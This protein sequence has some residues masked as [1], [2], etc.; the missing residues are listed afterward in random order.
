MNRVL[1]YTIALD[2]KGSR[3]HALMAKLLATSLQRTF[4]SGDVVIFRNSPQ[5]LFFSERKRVEEVYLPAGHVGWAAS[6]SWKWRVLEQIEVERYDWVFFVDCDCL[7]L[8]NIDHLLTG[9]WDFIYQTEQPSMTGHQ[10]NCFLTDEEMRS[11]A[12]R[13]GVNGG[14]VAFRGNR[15]REIAKCWAGIAEGEAQRKRWGEDQAALNRLV[16]DAPRYGWRR[17]AFE[18]GEIQFPLLYEPNWTRYMAA[19]LLHA[20][21]GGEAGKPAMKL[22]FLYGVFAQRFLHRQDGTH[23]DQLEH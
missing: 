2:G 7:A 4:F 19:S 12:W 9:D 15:C 20:A 16:L 10:Y 18:R 11:E 3:E 13:R 23:L 5:P 22:Q 1:L 17:R 14:T 21:Y 8:R 6:M